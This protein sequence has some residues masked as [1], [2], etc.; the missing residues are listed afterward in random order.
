M[1]KFWTVPTN[2]VALASSIAGIITLNTLVYRERA[3]FRKLEHQSNDA[4]VGEA[5]RLVPA[6]LAARLD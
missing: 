4:H 1:R 6:A 3:N 2:A 5:Q